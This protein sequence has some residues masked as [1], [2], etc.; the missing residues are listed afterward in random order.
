MSAGGGYYDCNITMHSNNIVLLRK[1]KYAIRGVRAFLNSRCKLDIAEDFSCLNCDMRMQEDDTAI[2][3]G[4]D[5]MFSTEI[6]IYTTDGHAIYTEDGTFINKGKDVLIGNHVWLGRRCILLKGVVIGNNSIVG[7]GAIVTKPFP[8][9]NAILAGFPA[10]VIKT[11]VNW[12][13][14]DPAHYKR[15]TGKKNKRSSLFFYSL[16]NFFYRLFMKE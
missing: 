14:K 7:L 12:D 9:S 4:S 10:K 11:G 3:I 15:V 6:C 16:R 5:C 1:S 13:R 2:F 8:I